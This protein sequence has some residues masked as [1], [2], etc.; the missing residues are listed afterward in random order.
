MGRYTVRSGEN[1]FDVAMNVYGGI[2]GVFDLL[3]CNQDAGSQSGLSLCDTLAPGMILEYTDGFTVNQDI[4]NWFRDN[5]IIVRNGEH[6]YRHT[7]IEPYITAYARKHNEAVL[8]A[9]MKAIPS[10]A[11]YPS[12]GITEDEAAAF[13]ACINNGCILIPEV[14]MEGFDSIIVGDYSCITDI[15]LPERIGLPYMVIK[16]A[17]TLSSIRYELNGG[18]I[19]IDWGD[20]TQSEIDAKSNRLVEAEHCYEDGGSHVIRIY[21]TPSLH[22][23]DLSETGGT[24]YPTREIAVGDFTGGTAN[25]TINK[26]ILTQ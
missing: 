14:T 22:V 6:I 15:Q 23:L 7:D 18:F 1:I 11:K 9:A 5:G 25:E 12:V 24:Y 21:G 19:I 16:Q 17:G 8:Q 3:V 10:V 4:I 20:N 13:I 2:E 26:L